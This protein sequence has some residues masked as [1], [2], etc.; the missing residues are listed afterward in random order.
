MTQEIIDWVSQNQ[1]RHLIIMQNSTSDFIS[2]KDF[3]TVYNI[4]K[5]LKI[6]V[7]QNYLNKINNP[8]S[9]DSISPVDLVE[10]NKNKINILIVED[11]KVNMLLTKTLVTKAF[12]NAVLSE[13]SNGLQAVEVFKNV[14]PEIILMDIQMPVMN[15]YEATELIRKVNK[16]VIIIALTAGVITGEKEKCL[17]I[18]MNDFILKPID[19]EYF[20]KTVIK[21]IK[22]VHKISV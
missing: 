5:P 20:E 11:N 3:N 7:L 4:I 19:K 15:G 9:S 6:N 12:P 17:D 21:W 13:A 2:N 14:S 22:T 18:G 10:V 8:F 1:E 16:D